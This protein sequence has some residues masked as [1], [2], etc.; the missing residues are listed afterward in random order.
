MVDTIDI[1]KQ[2]IQDSAVAVKTLGKSI[3]LLC[4]YAK[5]A[6]VYSQKAT[7]SA[8][9]SLIRAGIPGQ[10]DEIIQNINDDPIYHFDNVVSKIDNPEEAYVV[11]KEELLKYNK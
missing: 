5:V 3:A 2:Q 4:I 6:G 10:T 1:F 7:K 9:A 8:I 11:L